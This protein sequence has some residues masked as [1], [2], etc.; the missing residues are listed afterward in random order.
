MATPAASAAMPS[1]TTQVRSEP[2]ASARLAHP[3]GDS[4]PSQ[5]GAFVPASAAA[6]TRKSTPNAPIVNPAH[7]RAVEAT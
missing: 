5:P 6:R 3:T 7:P 1:R 4:Q 2:K